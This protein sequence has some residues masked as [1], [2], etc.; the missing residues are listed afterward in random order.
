MKK[1]YWIFSLL[2]MI[3]GINT[4]Y[5]GVTWGGAITDPSTLKD[6]SK[7]IIHTNGYQD[8]GN[9]TYKFLSAVKDSMIFATATE[10]ALERYVAFTLVSAKDKTVKGNAAFYLKNDYNGKYVTYVFDPKTSNVDGNLEMYMKYTDNVDKA[11]PV[12]I[13][14]VT[15]GAD[16]IGYTLTEDDQAKVNEETMMVLAECKEKDNTIIGI[17]C[18]LGNPGFANYGDWAAWWKIGTANV[19]D[20]YFEDLGALLAKVAELNFIGGTDPGQYDKALV[21]AYDAAKKAAEEAYAGSDAA[22]AK[23]AF[24]ALEEA[25]FN[26]SLGEPVPVKEG[27][28]RIESAFSA[29]IENQGEEAIKTIYAN[30]SS[31]MK[32]KNLDEND[33]TM[34]WQFI[35]RHDGT[36][37]LYNLGTAQYVDGAKSTA[38][39]AIYTM[40]DDSTNCGVVITG[41]GQSQFNLNPD[42]YAFHTGG[43]SDGK[44]TEGDV[45]GWN[46]G[47]S[48]GSAWYIKSVPEDQID[49]FKA[50]GQQNKLNRDLTNLYNKAYAKYQIGNSF[51]FGKDTLVTLADFEKDPNVVYS[52]ADHNTLNPSKD[53]LGYAGLLDNDTVMEANGYEK[54]Y[55]HSSW[56]VAPEG[57]PYLQFKLNK[58]VS[59]FGVYIYRRSNINQATDIY[60][61]VT[62]DPTTGEWVDAGSINGLPADTKGLEDLGYQSNGFELD[63]KYQYVRITWKSANGFTH[64]AGFHFHE[65]TL[66]QDCQNAQMGEEATNLKAALSKASKTIA[67]GTAT[68]QD[69]KDLQAAYD[70]YV[71]E[72]ADPTTLKNELNAAISLCDK[73][74]T[75]SMTKKNSEE[76]VGFVEGYPGV[77]T[78]EAKNTFKAVVDE[79]KKYVD[80]KDADGSFTKDGIK[81]NSEKLAAAVKT[82]K[83]SAPKFTVA[84]EKSEGL[85]YKIS[86]S[87]HYFD[88]SGTEP[89]KKVDQNTQEVLQIR[90]G[91]L[92]VAA[93]A[94]KDILNNAEIKVTGVETDAILKDKEAYALW[95]FINMGDTAYAIQNKATGLYIGEKTG[96]NA[97][98]SMTPAAYKISDLGYA[99]F[100]IE[101]SR[102]NG[103]SINPLHIQTDGQ[104]LVYWANKDLGGGSCFD[105]EPTNDNTKPS[106]LTYKAAEIIKGRLYTMCYPI[107]LG[108]VSDEINTQAYPYQIATIDPSK[109]ELT[110]T[111]IEDDN[112]EAGRP[113]FYIG[114]DNGLGVAEEP[115][116]A[117]TTRLTAQLAFDRKIVA[118][119]ATDNGLIGN[120]YGGTKVAAGFGIV[121]DTKGVQ[122]IGVTTADQQI[123]WNS[124]YID[125]A[126]I[127]NA[128]EPGSIVVKIDGDLATSIKDAI[129]N[130]QSGPV[131]VYSI[132][133]VLIKKNV[134]VSEAT[135]GLAKGIYIVGNKKVA[136]K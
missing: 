20:D 43:H 47:L 114:A 97:G 37:I 89:D 16:L 44:G 88:Y 17:N 2:L 135:K 91:R 73:A 99:T 69:I 125:A 128:E 103:E 117:D 86:Y 111:I 98:L 34:V 81:T 127:K 9:G 29:F 55:W 112:M 100:L 126:L 27:Y 12:I 133:G 54:T 52:N 118:T 18:N 65:A 33:A 75:P 102:L 6:G 108:I 104:K 110:L 136:V 119:P 32:W 83:E 3:M 15:D 63:G 1:I 96:G 71:A 4:A 57:T 59:A 131:N 80:D 90:K 58:P 56:G 105:I 36:W 28:Y 21:D 51:T 129:V 13:K 87:Q 14:T 79:V 92:Y 134:K 121:K 82:F 10:D 60:F 31:Q 26:L 46:G 106:A 78:D 122:S 23:T 70:A 132:D 35:D 124:A 7:I 68:E 8:E 120:Y 11:T 101:G 38:Q 24:L 130:A 61:Q 85:W 25:Y 40:T 116:A 74:A 93:D 50:I 49:G 67:S 76:L 64:F 77:Y 94:K 53:G 72:L 113:F 42:V 123:G 41:L 30:N 109:K 39:S 48:G 19:S 5:A 95:R 84:D 62:N 22:A 66:S 115:T 107:S 45:V